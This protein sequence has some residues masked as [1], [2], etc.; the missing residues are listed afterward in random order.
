MLSGTSGAMAG[1][2]WPSTVNGTSNAPLAGA[3]Y[4]ASPMN[5]ALGGLNSLASIGNNAS[6]MINGLGNGYNALTGL[7]SGSDSS[8]SMPPLDNSTVIDPTQSGGW[9]F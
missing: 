8:T 7:F 5:Q 4:G 9:S 1:L 6:G 3:A 2:P